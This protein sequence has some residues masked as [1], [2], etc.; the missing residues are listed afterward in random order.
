MAHIEFFKKS[1]KPAVAYMQSGGEK[2]YALA[3]ACGEIYVPPTAQLALRGLSV[4][5]QFLRGVLDKVGVEP[6]VHN[7]L[8]LICCTQFLAA[9][10][11]H[12]TFNR[13][14]ICLAIPQVSDPWLLLNLCQYLWDG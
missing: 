14:P 3:A 13:Y 8:F 7:Y 11:D 4:Q 1:G 9:T 6:Q 5:G 12:S 2:E 10:S